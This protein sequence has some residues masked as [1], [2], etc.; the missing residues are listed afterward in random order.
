MSEQFKAGE[1]AILY[2]DATRTLSREHLRLHGEEVE[3]VE[4][5]DAYETDLGLI[6]AY[7]IRHAAYDD[8]LAE[9]HELRRRRPPTTGEQ[10]IRSMFDAPPQPEKVPA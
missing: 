9:P 10:M 7:R 1:I 3:I 5:L 4:P 2:P 6:R 8:L